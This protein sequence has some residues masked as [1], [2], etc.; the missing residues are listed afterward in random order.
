MAGSYR[1]VTDKG[2][3]FTG[4]DRLDNL[5][6]AYEALDEMYWMIQILAGGVNDRIIYAERLAQRI[7]R[8]RH[9]P[10]KESGDA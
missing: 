8:D 9:R 10:C 6:D 5:G 2:G 1:H 4:I 7:Q 3:A